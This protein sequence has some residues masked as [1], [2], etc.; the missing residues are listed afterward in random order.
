MEDT[1]PTAPRDED[2]LPSKGT[3][4]SLPELSSVVTAVGAGISGLYLS[5]QSVVVTGIGAALSAILVLVPLAIT[6]RA[7]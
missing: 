2:P 7:R 3:R 5:T 1:T 6:R 4:P